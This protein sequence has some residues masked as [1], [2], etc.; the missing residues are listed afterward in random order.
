M[1]WLQVETDRYENG[2]G[3]ILELDGMFGW[4]IYNEEIEDEFPD[5]FIVLADLFT[6]PGLSVITLDPESGKIPN[7]YIPALAINDTFTVNNQAGMLSLNAQ[8]GDIA[9]RTDIPGPGM[10]VL[11]GDDPTFLPNWIPLTTRY[12]DW[13]TIQNKPTE[14]PSVAHDHDTRYYTKSETD[15]SLS[16]K[17]NISTP[18]SAAEVTEDISHRFVSDAEKNL[19]NNPDPPKW[20]VI[21]NKP[22]TFPPDSHD[23]DARYYTKSETDTSLSQKRNISTPI[24]AAEVITDSTHR[25][26]TD[27]QIAS[28]NA[29]GGG[30]A[31]PLNQDINFS[32][33]RILKLN[34]TPVAG[35]LEDGTPFFKKRFIFTMTTET[36]VTITHGINNAATNL[37]II[38]YD[39][40]GKNP[41]AGAS[42][43]L[44]GP[45][46]YTP[47]Q[48]NYSDT[49]ITF[50]RSDA[51]LPSQF[52]LTIT[53]I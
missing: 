18:I 37:R 41:V 42:P 3:W 2:S 12:S 34:N 10:F 30:L 48:I 46:M 26:V 51:S 36:V 50:R 19:W 33:G 39:V 38:G 31:N 49:V 40:Y 28:W 8:R 27:T 45:P 23:H 32:T 13:S 53:Y 29:G 14:Y 52:C 5:T 20:P 4:I 7:Q 47:S 35:W 11:S 9:I 22:V 16:Q 15:T 6:N 43:N 24:P 1:G 44:I 21:Q 17:R 25:F